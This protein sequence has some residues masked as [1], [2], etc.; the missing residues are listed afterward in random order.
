MLYQNIV[1]SLSKLMSRVRRW[2]SQVISS[3]L[4]LEISTFLISYQHHPSQ[5][6]PLYRGLIARGCHGKFYGK[7]KKFKIW[8]CIIGLKIFSHLISCIVATLWYSIAKW[9]KVVFKIIW[10]LICFYPFI[11]S[12]Q[13]ESAIFIDRKVIS[14]DSTTWRLYFIEYTGCIVV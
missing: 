3:Q 11:F 5:T 1:T 12:C 4:F 14:E 8:G 6:R 2:F 7:E 9:N 13:A 10:I